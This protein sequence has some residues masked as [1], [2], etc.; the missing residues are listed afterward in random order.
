MSGNRAFGFVPSATGPWTFYT[1]GADRTTRPMD[2]FWGV[3]WARDI[4]FKQADKLWRAFQQK[5]TSFIND[6]GGQ[7]R[8][9]TESI[10]SMRYD[11]DLIRNDRSV[12]DTSR[13]PSWISISG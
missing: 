1:L 2:Q 4:A 6:H 9:K 7:A 11:W 8:I 5:L 13:Q 12:Y 10:H 3:P